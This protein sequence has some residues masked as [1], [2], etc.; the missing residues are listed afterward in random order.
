MNQWGGGVK[1]SS[2]AGRDKGFGR[3]DGKNKGLGSRDGKN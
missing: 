2:R 1:D 3:R